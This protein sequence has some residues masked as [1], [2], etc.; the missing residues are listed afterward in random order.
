MDNILYYYAF[1]VLI[2]VVLVA[3]HIVKMKFLEEENR[4]FWF[5][6]LL[7]FNIYTIVYLLISPRYRKRTLSSEKKLLTAYGFIFALLISL[8]VIAA[9]ILS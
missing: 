6:L 9:N 8:P 4:A 1:F 2:Y 7:F 3:F 5:L